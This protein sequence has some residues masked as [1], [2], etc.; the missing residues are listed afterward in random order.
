MSACDVSVPR[1]A[2]SRLSAMDTLPMNQLLGFGA[3]YLH[4]HHLSW[5]TEQGG[6]VRKSLI[7]F[8]HIIKL[9]VKSLKR[10]LLP[11]VQEAAFKS[12]DE[13]DVE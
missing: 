5:V 10:F 12:D 6:Y 8:L 7:F 9:N 11:P 4:E 3:R 2:T 13:D 1:Q